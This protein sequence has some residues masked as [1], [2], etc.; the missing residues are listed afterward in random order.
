MRLYKIDCDWWVAGT[1]SDALRGFQ[2]ES[3]ADDDDLIDPNY[4]PR[5]VSRDEMEE[6]T[7]HRD[8]MDGGGTCTFAEEWDRQEKLTGFEGK[9]YLF[10]STEF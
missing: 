3:L 8:S 4:L 1:L 7:F 9:P 6:L 5:Q 2:N 10:A